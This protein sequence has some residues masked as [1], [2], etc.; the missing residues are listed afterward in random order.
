MP[1]GLGH[2]D[3]VQ[4]CVELPVAGAGRTVARPGWMTKPAAGLY[5]CGGRTRGGSGIG[6]CRR[7]HRGS[8]P[9]SGGRTRRSPAATVPPS[10]AQ[11]SL[12]LVVGACS[13]SVAVRWG[14]VTPVGHV[15][16]TGCRAARRWSSWVGVGGQH[17]DLLTSS[18]LEGVGWLCGTAEPT[19]ERSNPAPDPEA[20]PVLGRVLERPR[21]G[22]RLPR[23]S[24]PTSAHR[25]TS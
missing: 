25:R 9:R 4:C 15:A 18:V 6:R 17:G 19:T 14:Q 13:G 7:S 23:S 11:P 3:A 12:D 16:S 21:G 1:V 5:R 24:A 10:P 2:G 20:A 8:S 22:P